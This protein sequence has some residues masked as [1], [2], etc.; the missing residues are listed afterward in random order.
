MKSKIMGFV[1]VDVQD[2]ILYLSRIFRNMGK[3]VL[4][5]DYSESQALYY[6]IPFIPGMD[7][8]SDMIEYRNTYFTCGPLE[9]KQM[10]E[11]DVVL[12]F[13]GFEVCREFQFCTHVIYTTDYEKNHLER[14]ADIRH[15]TAEYQ[16]LVY[17]NAGQS[18]RVS[19]PAL[20]LDAV[21]E[22]CQYICNDSRREKSLRVQCQ[23]NDNF[24]FQGISAAFRN[25]LKETVAA[26]FPAETKDKSFRRSFYQAE[27]GV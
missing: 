27:T 17:R 4:M 21:R 15:E 26:V 20:K 11:F 6:S 7:A 19:K 24:G 2:T 22:E 8:Y 14:L 18:G 9:E 16:Q 12:V 23:Y 1:G 5:A 25:Y 3:R 13:F 10:K